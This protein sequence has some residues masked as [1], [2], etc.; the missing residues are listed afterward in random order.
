MDWAVK[1]KFGSEWKNI[2]KQECIPVGCVPSAAVAAGG[3][4]GVHP[5]MH[6]TGG[7]HPSMNWEGGVCIPACT[8]Q[9]G[10]AAC[11]VSA[12]PPWTE[13]SVGVCPEGVCPGGCL[14]HI[15]RPC[16]QNNRHLWKH[17]LAAT[18]LRT[19]IKL[20]SVSYYE[21][22][23]YLCLWDWSTAYVNIELY[24]YTWL[25]SGE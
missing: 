6:W 15:P 14:P 21:S 4:R 9:G 25:A 17:N 13:L 18:T 20:F 10:V 2:S 24:K 3:G 1:T 23:E 11:G 22:W 7:V 8:G 5:S 19:V 16:E 12:T